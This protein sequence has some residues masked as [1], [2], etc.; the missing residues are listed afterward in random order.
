[1]KDINVLMVGVGGQGVIL[2][3][4]A[5]AEIGMNAGYDVKKTDS[6]GMAQRGGSVV[7]NVRWGQKVFSPMIK[8]GEVDFLVS[9]EQVETARWAAYL[10]PSGV[11]IVADVVVIPISAMSGAVPYP[12]WDEIKSV[13]QPQTDQIFFVPAIKIG[14]E[15][16]NPKALNIVMMGALSTFLDLGD[17]AWLADIRRKVPPKFLDSSIQA[18]HKGVDE[19]KSLK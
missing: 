6:L 7:S 19:I 5:M 18:F 14:Q 11:A 9:F 16:N 8:K 17:E 15:V 2:A 10:K 4:D 3:S 13:L 1:M 12:S